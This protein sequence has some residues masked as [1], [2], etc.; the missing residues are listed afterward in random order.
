[1]KDEEWNSPNSKLPEKGH[2]VVV[3]AKK[4][5][6]YMGNAKNNESEWLDDGEGKRGIFCWKK[7]EADDE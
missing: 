2:R 7:I 3:I 6:I 4:E 5:L 1:M